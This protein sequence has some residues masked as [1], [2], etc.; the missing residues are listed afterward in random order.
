MFLF[1]T[2]KI[3]IWGMDINDKRILMNLFKFWNG[4]N[5][6]QWSPGFLRA[7]E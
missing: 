5:V 3:G 7:G 2:P 4:Y 6:D 1:K